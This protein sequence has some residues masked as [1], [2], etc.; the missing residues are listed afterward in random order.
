MV[1]FAEMDKTEEAS[2]GRGS[3]ELSAD[4][5]GLRC[6]GNIQVKMSSRQLDL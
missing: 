1:P 6:L 2:A 5:L 3:Q 4:L